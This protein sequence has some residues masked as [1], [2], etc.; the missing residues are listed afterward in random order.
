MSKQIKAPRV[1]PL[2]GVSTSNVAPVDIADTNGLCHMRILLRDS[3]HDVG[4]R[5]S[6]ASFQEK[7]KLF[8]NLRI[9]SHT[10]KCSLMFSLNFALIIK[11]IYD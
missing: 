2:E 10:A 9:D 4:G 7:S 5:R 11:T 8:C 6:N 3:L 1:T